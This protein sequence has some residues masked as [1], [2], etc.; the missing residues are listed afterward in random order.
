MYTIFRTLLVGTVLAIGG[1]AV[2]SAASATDP[3]IGTWK[4]NLAKSKFSPGPAPKSHTRTYTATADGIELTFD[5]VAADGTT[6]SGKSSYKYDGKDYPITGS[7]DF[8]TVALKRTDA[9]TVESTQK[10]AGKTVGTTM[11][12]VSKDG[13]VMT[14]KLSGKNAKGVAYDNVMVFDKQ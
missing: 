1:M 9:N 10:K 7:S 12:T 11:R 2:A 14:L 8:D 6:S 5:S 13:K 4:L 3:I